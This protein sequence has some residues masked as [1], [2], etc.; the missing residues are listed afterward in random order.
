VAAVAWLILRGKLITRKQADEL[1][2]VYKDSS[3]TWHAA[4]DKEAGARRE[5]EAA[6]KEVLE[7]SRVANRVLTARHQDEEGTSATTTAV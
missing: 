3:N 4:Y 7:L 1:I 5:Q 6:L 2:E